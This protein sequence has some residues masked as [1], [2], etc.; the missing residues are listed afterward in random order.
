LNLGLTY[1]MSADQM[2]EAMQVLKD[3][4]KDHVEFIDEEIAVGFNAFGD[5]SLGILFIYFIRKEQD[6]LEIQT[7][8]NL[9][10]LRR[11]GDKGLEMAF[12]TQ[13]VLHQQLPGS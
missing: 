7:K 5:F 10:I 2:E 12:P 4:A 11:F 1:D 3:I 8:M 6:N 9:A 13:T